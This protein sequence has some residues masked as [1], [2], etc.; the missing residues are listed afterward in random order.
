MSIASTHIGIILSLFRRN[1]VFSLQC[2]VSTIDNTHDLQN[3]A[4]FQKGS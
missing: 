2:Y 3:K 4:L 1:Y